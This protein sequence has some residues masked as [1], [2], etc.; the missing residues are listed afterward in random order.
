MQL[1]RVAAQGVAVICPY[2]VT[3][4]NSSGVDSLYVAADADQDVLSEVSNFLHRMKESS[5]GP[6]SAEKYVQLVKSADNARVGLRIST[7]PITSHI[8]VKTINADG[9]A[10]ESGKFAV[11]KLRCVDSVGRLIALAVD[12]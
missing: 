6:L 4:L 11:G 2:S 12:R 5:D 8:L 9:L 10:A 1:I 3:C 7:D